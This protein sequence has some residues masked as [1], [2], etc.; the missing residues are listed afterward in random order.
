MKALTHWLRVVINLDE[1]E[2][3]TTKRE[4]KKIQF[5]ASGRTKACEIGVFEGVNSARIS[6]VL[7]ESGNLYSIDPFFKGR[8]GI[9]YEKLIAHLHV[10]RTGNYSKVN[11][12]RGLSHQCASFVPDDLDFLFID[13]DHSYE[14]ISKD[15]EEYSCKV[16]L[17]G[18]VLL[19]DSFAAE[20]SR[21]LGSHTFFEEVISKDERF[22]FVERVDSMAVI[23]RK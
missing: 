19:H 5:Y 2:S 9:S 3:Q 12:L 14:G 23:R 7:S 4:R 17:N 1:P 13:G 16:K 20:N 18:L 10:K 8:L 11:W 21:A 6:Q 15:W 22:E